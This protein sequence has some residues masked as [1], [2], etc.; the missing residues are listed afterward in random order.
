MAFPPVPEEYIIGMG[1][2][3]VWQNGY[4]GSMVFW[5]RNMNSVEDQVKPTETD[6]TFLG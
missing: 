5:V 4:T 1:A 6:F 3:W 2:P